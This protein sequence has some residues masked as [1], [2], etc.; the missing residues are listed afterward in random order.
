MVVGSSLL[1][2]QYKS[3]SSIQP[4]GQR[5]EGNAQQGQVPPIQRRRVWVRGRPMRL[6]CPLSLS[7]VCW[8]AWQSVASIMLGYDREGLLSWIASEVLHEQL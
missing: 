8:Q 4:A 1:V 2:P 7:C 6:I 3:H 5:A